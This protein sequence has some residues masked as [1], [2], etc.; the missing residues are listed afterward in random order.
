MSK[1]SSMYRSA[2]KVF[3]VIVGVYLS[4]E[5]GAEGF[6]PPP[7]AASLVMVIAYILFF[8]IIYIKEEL[9]PEEKK[10]NEFLLFLVVF[11]YGFLDYLFVPVI[12]GAKPSDYL[13]FL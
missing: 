12:F 6:I 1:L 7:V 3:L 13:F 10:W 4:M 2:L 8:K 9:D 11:V 5:S